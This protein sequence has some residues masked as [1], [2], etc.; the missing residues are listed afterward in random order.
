MS[1]TVEEIEAELS[2]N[3]DAFEALRTSYENLSK[4]QL[5]LLK[6]KE[7]EL[8]FTSDILDKTKLAK[9]IE[10]QRLVVAQAAAKALENEK[11]SNNTLLEQIEEKIKKTKEAQK[12]LDDKWYTTGELSYQEDVR[13][14]TLTS[15]IP[16]LET[17]KVKLTASSVALQDQLDI[18]KNMV[19]ELE[20][21]LDLYK[22]LK[23]SQEFLLNKGKDLA[24]QFLNISKNSSKFFDNLNKTDMKFLEKASFAV[25]NIAKGFMSMITIPAILGKI[26]TASK[27]VVLE[28]ESQA[29]AL[30]SVTGQQRKYEDELYES[31]ISN[32]EFGLGLSETNESF[33]AL[34]KNLTNLTKISSEG[35]KELVLFAS[36]MSMLGVQNDTT[37]STLDN[38]S[39]ALQM[40]LSGAKGQMLEITAVAQDLNIDVAKVQ[41]SFQETFPELAVHGKKGIEV[42]KNLQAVF[43]TTGVEAKTLLG[44]FGESMNTF[45]QS[46]EVAGKLNAILGRDMFNSIDLLRAK[47]GERIQMIVRGLQLSGKRFADMGRFERLAIANAAGIKD[48][49]VAMRLFN[50]NMDELAVHQAKAEKAKENQEKFN[51]AIKHSNTFMQ[52]WKILWQNLAVAVQPVVWLLNQVVDLVS[53]LLSYFKGWTWV[54]VL[55]AIVITKLII[56]KTGWFAATTAATVATMASTAATSLQMMATAGMT[57]ATGVAIVAKKGLIATMWAGIPAVWGFVGPLL[58]FAGVLAAIAATIWVVI[59]AWKALFGVK[60]KRSSPAL[61][62]MDKVQAEHADMHSRSLDKLTPKVNKVAITSKKLHKTGT[63]KV[64]KTAITSKKLHKAGTTKGSPALWEMDKVQAEHADMHSRSL[65]KLTPKVNKTAITSKKLHKAGTTKGSPALWEINDVLAEGTKNY[66][67]QITSILPQMEK[68]TTTSNK[69]NT[70]TS[71]NNKIINGFSKTSDEDVFNNSNQI[72]TDKL[73]ELIARMENKKKTPVQV[74]VDV[75]FMDIDATKRSFRDAVTKA[76]NNA[77]E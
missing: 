36:R 20:K 31:S 14:K 10:E 64:N 33:K 65:D 74:T 11:K 73:D 52:K 55:L 53:S 38:L 15:Q 8:I 72:V 61:W 66:S 35:R 21:T 34:Y 47:E 69:L 23:E 19:K 3:K 7:K 32:R 41:T 56:A 28:L 60:K 22:P 18:H 76:I 1:K 63:S 9:E 2:K 39:L 29:A 26:Y 17:Q 75:N 37:A 27:N 48:M 77:Y 40:S 71:E 30:A 62:E 68:M 5:K 58:L 50:M 25:T 45:E 4:E 43:K 44:I 70:V 16:L 12:L 24:S 49:N 42:F 59:K 13:L 57:T 51:A 46:A 54:I 6:Q 67:A